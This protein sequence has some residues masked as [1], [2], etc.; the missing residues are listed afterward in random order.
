MDKSVT[1]Y[2]VDFSSAP[3]RKKPIAVAVGRLSL[4]LDG[5]AI[6]EIDGLEWLETLPAFSDFLNRPGP[7]LGGFDLPF[8]QPRS[9]LTHYGWP[10]HWDAFVDFFCQTP[11]ESLRDCFRQW[12]N[13]RPVGQKFAW[14]QADKPAGSSP[15]M[16]WTN[17]PVAWMMQAGIGRMKAAGLV[18]P[19]HRYPGSAWTAD[20]D[21]AADQTEARLA[22]EAYP[23]FTARQVT[24]ASYKSDNPGQQTADREM[25]RRR[26]VEAMLSGEAG[27]TVACRVAEPLRDCMISEPRG[28]ALDAV[29]CALQAAQAAV[30]PRFGLPDDLD[31]L[32][33]WIATV[34]PPSG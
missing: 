31:P 28:D 2:G 5:R 34:P 33:G 14:R 23:G 29:I 11:R 17:P 1:V 4:G 32:E 25:A 30:Q 7:W 21:L 27:L 20:G 18:F 22:L 10:L 9:L 19:A 13:A 24:R 16:R 12:C 15:A 6:V 3:C 26:I 8:G